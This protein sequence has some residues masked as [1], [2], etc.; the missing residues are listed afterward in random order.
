MKKLWKKPKLI[1]LVRGKP[2][3][4]VLGACKNLDE[5]S[6]PSDFHLSIYCLIEAP[7]MR[8]CVA[9]DYLAYT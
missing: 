8:D 4:A 9:C 2:E 5:R 7:G 6:G 3:E 1:V